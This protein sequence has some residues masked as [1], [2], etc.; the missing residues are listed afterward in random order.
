MK[1]FFHSRKTTLVI[2]KQQ[3]FDININIYFFLDTI[4]FKE[5]SFFQNKEQLISFVESKIISS[6]LFFNPY[7]NIMSKRLYDWIRES[8]CSSYVVCEK[9][10]LPDSIYLDDTGFLNDS[11]Y[12]RPE[13]WN[14][15]L[16]KEQ[17]EKIITYT[18]ELLKSGATREANQ[19]RKSLSQVKEELG[20]VANRR[21]LFVPFQ[22][23]K[24]A[25]VRHFCG[26]IKSYD[27]F[28]NA[29][30]AFAKAR[31]DWQVLYK[32]H[33]NEKKILH[34]EN[35]ICADNYH[36]YDL[37]QLSKAVALINS[38]VGIFS[39]LL[40][41]PTYVFGDAWYAHNALTVSVNQ[42]ATLDECL[43]E[44]FV[45]DREMVLRFLY[46]L[47]FVFYSFV[48]VRESSFSDGS[49][50][51]SVSIRELGYVPMIKPNYLG[52]CPKNRSFDGA[53]NAD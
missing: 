19:A 34:I 5:A 32:N 21:V 11:D 51:V 47:R 3:S 48:D 52:N 43:M 22:R 27:L 45:P 6:V 37:I 9:G 50:A 10:A 53:I 25:V 4:I 29:I 16:T 20:I 31:P 2:R 23:Q 38:G 26:E 12:Y 41:K 33:P 1:D 17:R 36:V 40:N 35:G 49:S 7:A 39:L 28:Y 24:D 18:N 14:H 15:P 42:D 8:R 44:P 13:Y 46:Y 30:Q